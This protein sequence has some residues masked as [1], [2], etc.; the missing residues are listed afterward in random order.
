M[1]RKNIIISDMNETNIKNLK[2]LIKIEYGKTVSE[3]QL[4]NVAITQF[5]TKKQNFNN[6]LDYMDLLEVVRCYNLI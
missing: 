3:T 5:F 6:E 1:Q 4:I 2:K